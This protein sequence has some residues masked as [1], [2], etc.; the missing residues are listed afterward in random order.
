MSVVPGTTGKYWR[1]GI[2]VCIIHSKSCNSPRHPD[3]VVYKW[4]LFQYAKKIGFHSVVTA[5]ILM[6]QIWRGRM[7]WY[8]RNANSLLFTIDIAYGQ[9]LETPHPFFQNMLKKMKR[10]RCLPL[11]GTKIP[12]AANLTSEIDSGSRNNI[13][14][15]QGRIIRNMKFNWRKNRLQY[16]RNSKAVTLSS[17]YSMK[18][19]TANGC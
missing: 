16:W 12:P 3:S 7:Q 4:F 9:G 13:L 15:M 1:V 14:L 5:T 2:S 11:N 6:A 17:E 18:M 10:T 8:S 19:F